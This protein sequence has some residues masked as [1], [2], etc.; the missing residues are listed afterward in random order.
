MARVDGPGWRFLFVE[1]V[2]LV[3]GILSLGSMRMRA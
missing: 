2:F 3:V 1:V